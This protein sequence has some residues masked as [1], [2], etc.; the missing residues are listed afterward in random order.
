MHTY[1]RTYIHPC[2]HT[3]IHTCRHTHIHTYIQTYKPTNLQTYIHTYTHTHIHTYKHTNI[4]T[5]KHT[6]IHTHTNI[7]TNIQTY[8]H[9]YI[10]LHVYIYICIY[11][12]LLNTY[13]SR[14]YHTRITSYMRRIPCQ[15][16][17]MIAHCLQK[18]PSTL[19]RSLKKFEHFFV[20][21]CRCFSKLFQ[22]EAQGW[23]LALF[24]QP[25]GWSESDLWHERTCF[26]MA[27]WHL[28]TF[29]C[30]WKLHLYLQVLNTHIE[31]GVFWQ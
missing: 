7:H 17:P 26:L 20:S 25:A 15:S 24:F 18:L 16:C 28:D 22:L 1:V 5:Y 10:H 13:I 14:V 11:N 19:F 29:D 31:K 12:I 21:A 8:I 9:T 30:S 27:P 4:Q 23:N 2:M 6:Y 3:Y